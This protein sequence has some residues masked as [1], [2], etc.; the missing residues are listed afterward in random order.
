MLSR[1]YLMVVML[2]S[3]DHSPCST[4]IIRNSVLVIF[5]HRIIL[6]LDSM[7]LSDTILTEMVWTVRKER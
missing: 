7:S 1:Y 2:S 3:S 6:S 4:G 5:K